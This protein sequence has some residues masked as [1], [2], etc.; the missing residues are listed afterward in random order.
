MIFDK[1]GISFAIAHESGTLLLGVASIIGRLSIG[2]F[3]IVARK[4]VF[5]VGPRTVGVGRWLRVQTPIF[6]KKS[7]TSI[8]PRAKEVVKILKA[9]IIIAIRD[10]EMKARPQIIA[11]GQMIRRE[12]TRLFAKT[13]AKRNGEFN[14][15]VKKQ[16]EAPRGEQAEDN[17]IRGMISEDQPL[18]R[19]K[20][21]NTFGD[22]HAG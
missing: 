3:V 4:A 19:D 16:Q 8:N 1:N 7:Y 22:C 18:Q 14:E 6:F 10:L 9:L 17:I 5:D 12:C 11:A 2:L 15:G 13:I 21:L 20:G